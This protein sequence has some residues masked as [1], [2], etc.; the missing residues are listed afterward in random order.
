[1]TRSITNVLVVVAC[2]SFAWLK[3]KKDPRMRG[4]LER[5]A[6]PP[7]GACRYGMYKV[8]RIRL[9]AI[10]HVRQFIV[11]SLRRIAKEKDH[12]CTLRSAGGGHSWLLACW[13]RGCERRCHA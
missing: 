12:L 2:G 8:Y 10:R 3:L 13:G 11:T 5:L 7:R 4:D 9:P 6:P 1:M